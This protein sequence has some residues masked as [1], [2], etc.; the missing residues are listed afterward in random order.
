MGWPTMDERVIMRTWRSGHGTSLI[1]MALALDLL[2]VGRR[3]T[4]TIFL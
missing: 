1:E 3:G 4:A 2:S